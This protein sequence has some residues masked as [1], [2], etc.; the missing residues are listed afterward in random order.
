MSDE[1]KALI[2][3]IA[4]S[5]LGV[6][7]DAGSNEDSAGFI[8]MYRSAVQDSRYKMKPG[9]AY[10]AAFVSWVCEHAGVPLV[11]ANGQGISYVPW[12]IDFATS[13]NIYTASEDKYSPEIGDAVCYSE[14]GERPDHTGIVVGVGEDFFVSVEGNYNNGVN[15]RRVRL[16]SPIILGYFSPSDLLI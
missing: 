3:A 7:E 1:T 11:H 8:A 12:L 5:Q 9:D 15:E 13:N 2:A 14:R 10:C 4:R 6:V 16:D